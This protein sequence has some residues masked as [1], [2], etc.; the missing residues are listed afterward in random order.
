MGP[1]HGVGGGG[2]G[3]QVGGCRVAADPCPAP[4]PSPNAY[5]ALTRRLRCCWC[6]SYRAAPGQRAPRLSQSPARARTRRAAAQHMV[7]GFRG[8]RREGEEV[9]GG[10]LRKIQEVSISSHMLICYMQVIIQR[11]RLLPHRVHR[12]LPCLR[13]FCPLPPCVRDSHR[14]FRRPPH[15]Q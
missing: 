6:R 15:S 3:G 10:Q 13:A 9:P 11:G 4:G 1:G 12:V 5:S 8:V 14:C 7:S 2:G